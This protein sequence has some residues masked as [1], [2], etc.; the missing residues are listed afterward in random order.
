MPDW[1]SL[2]LFVGIY[3]ALQTWILPKM[4]VST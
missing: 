2:L 4:G 3:I 1:L